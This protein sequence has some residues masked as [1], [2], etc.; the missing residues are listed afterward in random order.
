MLVNCIRLQVVLYSEFQQ[1]PV[2]QYIE[3]WEQM[4]IHIHVLQNK[5]AYKWINDYCFS[6]GGAKNCHDGCHMNM[7]VPRF[8][9]MLRSIFWLL[10]IVLQLSFSSYPDIIQGSCSR[11]LVVISIAHWF[12]D[13]VWDVFPT[14][15][16]WINFGMY[17]QHS[18]V[19][20]TIV[21]H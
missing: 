7:A 3:Q 5:L 2:C 15:L 20:D 13:K 12:S 1:P 10:S 11:D 16:C 14:Q 21:Y 19:G 8:C 17:F 6:R 18:C 4:Q 9:T